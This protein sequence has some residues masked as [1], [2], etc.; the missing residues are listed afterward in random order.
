MKISFIVIGLNEGW[1]LE[2]CFRSIIDA[3]NEL[4][5]L[6][7]EIIYVDSASSDNSINIANEVGCNRVIIL[8][9]LRNPAIARNIG[10]L[11]ATYNILVFLD[12]DMIIDKDFLKH[13]IK[14]NKLLHPIVAG[15]GIDRIINKDGSILSEKLYHQRETSYFKVITGGAFIIER[16]IWEQMNGMDNRFKRGADPELGLRLARQQLLQMCI[17]YLFIIHQNDKYGASKRKRIKSLLNLSHLYGSM[18]IYRKTFFSSHT[19][20]R[21][22]QNEKSLIALVFTIFL[23]CAMANVLY[24]SLYFVFVGIRVKKDGNFLEAFL[25]YILRDVSVLLAFLFFHPKRILTRNIPH[26]VIK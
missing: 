24:I 18:L 23:S 6:P 1:K 12:G 19:M 26:S 10:A 3:V 17:P 8:D 2:N 22:F 16:H 11:Y 25:Y 13:A 5:G 14:D 21:F 4:D 9:T 7:H 20:K 15:G